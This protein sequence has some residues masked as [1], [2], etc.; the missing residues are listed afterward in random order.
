MLKRTKKAWLH[1]LLCHTQ[2]KT[3]KENFNQEVVEMK[4]RKEILLKE[5]ED[6]SLELI[7]IQYKLDAGKRKPVPTIPIIYPE[8]LT[9]DPFEVICVCNVSLTLFT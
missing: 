2:I 4:N 5:L 8:E 3:R 6:I 9:K 7:D 1:L